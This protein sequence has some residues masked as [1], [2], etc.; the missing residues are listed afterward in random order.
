MTTWIST[1]VL[2]AALVSRPASATP[3]E[4]WVLRSPGGKVAVAVRL[5]GQGALAYLVSL[6]EATS[7]LPWSPLGIIREDAMFVRDLRFVGREQRTVDETYSLAHGKTRQ[8]RGHAQE[9]TL[10]FA[11]RGGQ[12]LDLVVRA[13]DEG[14]AFRYRFPGPDTVARTVRA[15]LTGFRLPE[16][17]SGW[18][19]PYDIPSQ[20]TPAYENSFRQVSFGTPSPTE[21][22]WAF[23]ALFRTPAGQW[24]LLTEAGLDRG[25]AGTHLEWDFLAAAYRIR[26]PESGEGEGVGKVFPS[27]TLPWETPWRVAMVGATAADIVE[28]SLVTH[29]ASPAAQRDWSWVRPGRA[30][31]SWWSDSPSPKNPVALRRFIDLA[32]EMGWEYSLIDANWNEMPAD[33]LQALLSY[34]Q[35]KG[36]APLLWYNSGGP[37]NVVTEAPRDRLGERERRRQE[38]KW[39]RDA[40]VKGIKVDFFQSDKQDRIQQYLD[41]LEDAAD[42]GLVVN[43]H[44]ATLPR[45]WQR[46]YPH[47]VTVEA[48]KGAEV[49]KFGAEYPAMAPAHNTM[50]VFTRNVVGPMDYTPVT[51][52]D[53]DHPHLTTNAHELA[54]SVIFESG[55]QH[56]ADRAE[57][58]LGLRPE[59][60][61]FLQQ[62]PAAWD[63]TRFLAGHP[64]TH[65][66]VARR[67]GTEWYVGG[68]SGEQKPRSVEVD[69]SFLVAPAEM[70]LIRDS[71]S[72]RNLAAER[73]RVRPGEKIR[74]NVLPRGG[75]AMRFLPVG[76]Q[77]Q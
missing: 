14:V 11:N 56:F 37:H 70:V 47:L 8:A 16:G 20:Y 1:A 71:N 66:V 52:S 60:K 28:S 9:M 5:D 45:G 59:A 17:S 65:A 34:A 76:S 27:S 68:I 2:L 54:L 25:Y 46:T 26:F 7:V 35:K 67:K 30:S 31:W 23:P 4:E 33:T 77:R 41:I 13:Y 44:G 69:L 55:I 29:L 12:R 3:A 6:G 36:V 43:F 61:R 53:V 40:G 10:A 49:Y 18:M 63:E 22:G 32:A 19:L 62:V 57:A 21:V 51:F 74:V 72:P 73:R 48:V 15:E 58:Y 39:L 38:F 50:L 42:F 64:G 75:F 24:T